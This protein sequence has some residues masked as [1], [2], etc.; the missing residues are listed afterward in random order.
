VAEK[1]GKKKT[2][3]WLTR[4]KRSGCLKEKGGKNN[5]SAFKKVMSTPAKRV[6]G[7]RRPAS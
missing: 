6:K 7:K 5:L 2:D 4:R 1:G 3:V